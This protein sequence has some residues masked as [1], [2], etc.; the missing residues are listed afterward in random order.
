VKFK[1]NEINTFT[2][3]LELDVLEKLV[4][5]NNLDE[6]NLIYFLSIS[7][8]LK[9]ASFHIIYT[10]GELKYYNYIKKGK[11]RCIINNNLY[12]TTDKKIN[13]AKLEA[14]F[15]EIKISD[16]NELVYTLIN[17][18]KSEVCYDIEIVKHDLNFEIPTRGMECPI[19]SYILPNVYYENKTDVSYTYH[20]NETSYDT[21]KVKYVY[22]ITNKSTL[23]Y[24]NYSNMDDPNHNIDDFNLI[25]C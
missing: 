23:L 4:I 15:E 12:I 22:G 1:N 13:Y 11:K 9:E 21:V 5:S 6:S 2:S 25:K 20:C 18:Y 3:N 24:E 14:Y 7:I 19:N 8:E 10:G 16:P 17:S